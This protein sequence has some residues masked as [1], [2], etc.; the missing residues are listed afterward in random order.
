MG[1]P[2]VIPAPLLSLEHW[3]THSLRKLSLLRQAQIGH[4]PPRFVVTMQC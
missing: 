3:C 2:T 1:T 4:L